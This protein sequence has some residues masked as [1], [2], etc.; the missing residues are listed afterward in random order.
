[1]EIARPLEGWHEFYGLLGT[2]AATL[3]GLLF[4]AASIGSG[5]FSTERQSPTQTFTTPIL[6]HYSYI[7]FVSLVALVPVNTDTSLALIIGPS[8]AAG[9]AYSAFISVRVVRSSGITAIE[10]HFGYGASAPAVY[11]V[12]LAAAVCIYEHSPIGPELLAVALFGLM[13]VNIR[14]SWDLTVFFAQ[15]RTDAKPPPPSAS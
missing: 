11:L 12:V 3:V 13:I 5:Y 6:A 4:V 8:A 7:L 9:L 10:D 2:A 15:R 14:N 1:M